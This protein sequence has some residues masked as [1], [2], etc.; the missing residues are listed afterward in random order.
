MFSLE[1]WP[2]AFDHCKTAAKINHLLLEN[3]SENASCFS[4]PAED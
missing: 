3:P 1:S 4:A 2:E